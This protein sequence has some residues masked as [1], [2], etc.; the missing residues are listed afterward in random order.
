MSPVKEKIYGVVE[1][2]NENQ[3][4]QFWQLICNNFFVTEK[5]WADIEEVEPDEFDLQ[6]L[7]E[8]EQDPDCHEFVSAA[9]AYKELGLD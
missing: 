8:I 2:M 4:K 3:A 7:R 5:S 9:D 6:M 1:L